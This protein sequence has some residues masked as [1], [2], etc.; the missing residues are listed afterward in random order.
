VSRR[1]VVFR[2]FASASAAGVLYFAAIAALGFRTKAGS[3]DVAIV[4]GNE[5]LADG[6]PSPRLAARL[7]AAFD[8]FEVGR[9]QHIIVSGGMGKSGHSEAEAMADYLVARS[10]PEARIVEDPEGVN[11]RA[12]AVNAARIMAEREWA[13]AMAVSQFFHLPRTRLALW[14]EGVE[15]TATAYPSHYE[16]RDIYSLAREAVALPVYALGY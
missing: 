14:Q 2:V 16:R 8:A 3:A 5:V 11:T 1:I 15:V 7:D 13:T 6:M 12:T 9:V 4:L 10:V